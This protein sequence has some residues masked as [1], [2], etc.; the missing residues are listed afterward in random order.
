[1]TK[2]SAC[3][4]RWGAP[5]KPSTLEQIKNGAAGAV[6]LLR[7]KTVAPDV[8]KR[9]LSVCAGCQH[10]K[11]KAIGAAVLIQHRCDLCGCVLHL[12]AKLNAEDGGNCPIDKW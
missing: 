2:C 11:G 9:R 10:I 12:K 3:V 8:V 6:S 7:G 5:S 1:M 4:A